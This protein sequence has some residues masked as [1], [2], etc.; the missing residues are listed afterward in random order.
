[1]PEADGAAIIRR[2]ALEI[3]ELRVQLAVAEV[4]LEAYERAEVDHLARQEAANADR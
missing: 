4:R 3:A 2:L 1:M